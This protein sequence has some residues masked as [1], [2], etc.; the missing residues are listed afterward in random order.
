MMST[1]LEQQ[2]E[3]QYIKEQV[4][5][6]FPLLGVTMRPLS[7]VAD[8]RVRTAATDGHRII[9]SPKF[10][11][12]LSDEQK[13]FVFAHEVMHVAFNHILR[14]KGRNQRLWNIATDSVINQILKN[15][16]LPMTEG[17][18]DIA[19]AVNHSAEEMYEKLLKKKEQREQE[20]EQKQ[21]QQQSQSGGADQPQ[22][23]KEQNQS[24]SNSEQSSDNQQGS[25]QGQKG[26]SSRSDSGSSS[27]NTDWDVPRLPRGWIQ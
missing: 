15:E 7:I 1:V 6:K 19:E 24:D 16:K 25:P 14:S 2:E 27:E 8:D 5:A 3:I 26:Q 13:Q 23:Q 11:S 21:E 12:T 17:G 22:D 18:V 9:Y 20:N 4:L 10:F